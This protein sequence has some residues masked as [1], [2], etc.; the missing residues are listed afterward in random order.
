MKKLHIL[1]L[2]I[3]TLLAPQASAFR[4]RGSG[5][6]KGRD[7]YKILGVPRSA[8]EKQIKKAFK[9]QSLKFH[10]DKNPNDDEALKKYQDI[11]SAYDV[12]SDSEKRRKY[13]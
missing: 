13:D 8:N 5:K 2:F 7:F 12:L 1:L 10:P 9:Q 4:G 3:L 6:G 11:S